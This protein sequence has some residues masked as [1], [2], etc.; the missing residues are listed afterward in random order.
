MSVGRNRVNRP[1]G[2]LT[3]IRLISPLE[4]APAPIARLRDRRRFQILFGPPKR[5]SR[6]RL[7]GPGLTDLGQTPPKPL[8]LTGDVDP[9]HMME[10]FLKSIVN[11]RV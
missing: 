3:L 10:G 7:L 9:Y 5:S 4:K 2:R 1:F 11:P 8:I 6:S